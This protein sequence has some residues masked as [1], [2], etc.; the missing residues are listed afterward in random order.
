MPETITYTG[1]AI[2]QVFEGVDE[3]V[4]NEMLAVIEFY[5]KEK[6]ETGNKIEDVHK[7]NKLRT[8]F[9]KMI[10]FLVNNKL[11]SL[12]KNQRC[13]ICTGALGDIVNINGAEYKLLEPEVYKGLLDTFE[14][15]DKSNPFN[16]FVFDVL[17]KM[18]ALAEEKLDLIDTSGK[19][20]RKKQDVKK[21]PK[22]IKAELEWKRNDALKAGANVSRMISQSMDKIV[23]LDPKKINS[24]KTNFTYLNGYFNVL[25]KGARIS[26]QEKKIK[27]AIGGKTDAISKMISDF[28]KLYA[29]AFTRMNESIDVLKEKIDI[30]KEAE[31][32]LKNVGN[33][34]AAQEAKAFTEFKEDH[35]EIIKRDISIVNSIVVGASEKASNRMPFSGARVM[36]NC[37]LPEIDNV[38]DE[39]IST[40]DK[41]VKS[42]E[43]ILSFHVNAFPK[44][45]DGVYQ[46]PPI[47][48]E[49]IRNFVEFMD[50]RFIMGII[51][52]ES[53]KKGANVTFS[54]VDFQVMR[55]VGMY[56]A[57][58]SVYDY[59]GEI[60][61]GTYMGDY[62]GRLEKTAQVKWTGSEKKMNMVMSAE[63]VDA[64]SR[65]DAVNDYMNFFFNALNG[66]GPPPKM[67]KRKVGVLLR[68]AILKDIKT[69]VRLLLTYVAQSEPQDVRDTILMFTD[70]SYEAAKDMVR[71][72]VKEDQMVQRTLGNN[73]DVVI[74]KIFGK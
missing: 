44:D 34:E 19:K 16:G 29:E 22:K 30:I 1:E 51:S 60:N 9:N 47:L 42:L 70:R 26:E 49:P 48:I 66:L 41:V 74:G 54:A 53:G 39:Y 72:I 45:E 67:S 18:R 63:L 12:N 13:F 36:L 32:D 37:Q 56:L 3:E 50:D 58:D 55:A 8:A 62:T 73:P 4:R 65:D 5:H 71:E 64:A 40:P 59:R 46:I 11:N 20:K 25:H 68:Y 24:L 14:K 57:K 28:S 15:R 10:T 21:D 23:Q 61:A 7:V 17:E 33:V 2:S 52:A 43:K 38:L 6:G 31:E 69:N 27:I 35:I